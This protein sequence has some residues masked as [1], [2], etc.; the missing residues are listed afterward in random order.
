M[1]EEG[2]DAEEGLLLSRSRRPGS[3][4]LNRGESILLRRQ[5]SSLFTFIQLP[6]GTLRLG[7]VRT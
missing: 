1:G 4:S 7:S 2:R 6:A 3:Q 5:D